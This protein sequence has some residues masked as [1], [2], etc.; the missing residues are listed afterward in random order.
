MAR[1]GITPVQ[2]KGHASRIRALDYKTVGADQKKN[3]ESCHTL[4]GFAD[5]RLHNV[6]F[7]LEVRIS[8]S[9]DRLAAEA[10]TVDKCTQTW[11]H[12]I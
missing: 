4:T 11:A 6:V 9:Q 1:R 10:Y 12:P 5:S 8:I 2:K 3:R 7:V